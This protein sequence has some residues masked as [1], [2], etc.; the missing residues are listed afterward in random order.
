MNLSDNVADYEIIDNFLASQESIEI[1]NMCT[2]GK[3]PYYYG[4]I[5]ADAFTNRSQLNNTFSRACFTHMLVENNKAV[6]DF[7]E[8]VEPL[9]DKLNATQLIRVK[10]NCYPPTHL[11]FEHGFH[12]DFESDEVKTAIYYI[13]TNDGYTKLRNNV[14]IESVQNRFA[15]FKNQTAH[16]SSTSTTGYRF[17][18][19][20]NW[21]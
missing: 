18:I 19:N 7:V 13:N 3:V 14:K 9:L 8:P 17:I 2:S 20:L 16:T 21:I 6:S 15:L 4:I 10:I 5:L 12:I 11:I 1:Y